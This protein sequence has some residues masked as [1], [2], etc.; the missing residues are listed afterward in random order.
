[1]KKGFTLIELIMLIVIVA[2]IAVIAIPI[3]QN[4][5][6]NA[7]LGV[8]RSVGGALKQ[9]REFYF[10]RLVLEGVSA[11]N[12]NS[13]TNNFNTFVDVDGDHLSDRNTFSIE[14]SVRALLTDPN[15]TVLSGNTITFN[16]KSGAVA[17][18]TIDSGTGKVAET[19]TG[20]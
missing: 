10:S 17:T 2:I 1:M 20:F 19:F 16:F 14:N 15:A 3:F 12:A 8:A 6:K 11:T 18:Y 13:L 9:A 4:F 7:E 5:Q